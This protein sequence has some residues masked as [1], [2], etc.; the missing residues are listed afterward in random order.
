MA[1]APAVVPLKL[2]TYLTIVKNSVG[3]NTFRTFY[4]KVGG[5]KEDIMRDGDLSCAFFVSFLLTGLGLIERVHGTVGGTVADMEKSG[6]KKTKA[7]KP[8]A[9]I[10]WDAKVDENGESHKHIGFYLGG[11]E[12]VSNN[13]KL[14]TPQ[15]HNLNPL[16]RKI[17]AYYSKPG[18]K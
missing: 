17:L 9:V 7:P 4:A 10:V 15:L 6:W 11:D 14:R 5:K 16:G 12:A 2:E 1:K 18:L 13:S 3:S 8:G